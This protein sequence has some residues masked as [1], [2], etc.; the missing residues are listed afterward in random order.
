MRRQGRGKALH[1]NDNDDRHHHDDRA[2]HDNRAHHDDGASG[3]LDAELDQ[4]R[5][6]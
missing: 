3:V 2:H 4:P 6:A 1:H 5:R